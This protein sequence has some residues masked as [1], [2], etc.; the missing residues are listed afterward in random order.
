MLKKNGTPTR[1][2]TIPTGIMA[3]R[4]QVL[5]GDGG[6]GEHQSADQRAG[7][8]IKAMVFAEEHPRNM[9]RHQADKADWPDKGHRK[10]RQYADPQQRGQA[11]AA[12]VN[13]KAD[14]PVLAQPQGGQLP[15][16][17]QRQGHHQRQGDQQD[18]D[19]APGGAVDAAHGPEHQP[20]QRVFVG[21]ELQHRDQGVKG[22]DQRDAEQDDPGG[23]HLG[24][25]GDA[26][27]QQGRTAG[28]R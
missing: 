23:G 14:G 3:P 2:V 7:G 8:Q 10:R 27:Q 6:R 4:D 16:A 12:N 26:V 21:D 20:L 9:R 17:A 5:R 1:E 13:A 11:Q 18:G 22:K 28:R 15:R 19:F 24:P 25:A